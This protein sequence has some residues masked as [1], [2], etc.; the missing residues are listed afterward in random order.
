MKPAP[1]MVQRV[2][3]AIRSSA[4]DCGVSFSGTEGVA[5]A[6]IKAMRNPTPKMIDA[7]WNAS[8]NRK[9]GANV[10]TTHWQA[11]IDAALKEDTTPNG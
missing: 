3:E 10:M 6:A 11:M 4:R 9:V 8:Y 1:E 5:R 2:K 7:A